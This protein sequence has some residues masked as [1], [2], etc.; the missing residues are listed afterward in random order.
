MKNIVSW[1]VVIDFTVSDHNAI[2]FNIAGVTDIRR[3]VISEEK[4]YN[5]KKDDWTSFALL[6][7][8]HITPQV[9]RRLRDEHSDRAVQ[10]LFKKLYLVCNKTIKFKKR[11]IRSVPW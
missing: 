4:Y 6:L 5:I 11:M 9:K 1:K 2:F 7:K 10:L 8:E 3:D